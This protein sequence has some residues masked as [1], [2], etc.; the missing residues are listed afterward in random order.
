MTGAL[1]HMKPTSTKNLEFN[2]PY[3][4]Q[5]SQVLISIF[6]AGL[7]LLKLCLNAW[8][9]SQI[10]V[11]AFCFKFCLSVFAGNVDC[12]HKL[13]LSVLPISNSHVDSNMEI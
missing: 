10:E 5:G 2:V 7:T 9:S 3:F 11:L 13:Y 6:E 8:W 4:L 12:S 1:L